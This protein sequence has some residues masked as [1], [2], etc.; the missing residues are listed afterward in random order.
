MKHYTRDNT[1]PV[2]SGQYAWDL[3]ATVNEVTDPHY[4]KVVVCDAAPLHLSK[5]PVNDSHDGNTLETALLTVT[6]DVF[7]YRCPQLWHSS[8]DIRHQWKLDSR[9]TKG[10]TGPACLF[11]D[12]GDT[13]A[14]LV[15]LD[16]GISRFYFM[17]G[18]W[19]QSGCI[20]HA[21]GPACT[22]NP[23]PAHPSIVYAIARRDDE[24]SV[25]TNTKSEGEWTNMQWPACQVQLPSPLKRLFWTSR[26]REQQ[27]NP[28]A[29][30]SQSLNALG[31]SP[32]AEAIV[33]HPC[34]TGWQDRW[35][36][37]HWSFV[38]A[39]QEWIVSGV[40][41]SKVRGIPM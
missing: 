24:L 22:Y 21:T 12:F 27:G 20:P 17:G 16:D 32:N 7:H 15:P 41:L 26:Q 4:G 8:R 38:T 3:S 9:I 23:N 28:M 33:F 36:V 1:I 11:T 29:I 19:N 6:G 40:V 35:M 37:L 30:V 14:A 39:T 31:H 2:H 25:N 34:G 18:A 5:V 10:A 13:L